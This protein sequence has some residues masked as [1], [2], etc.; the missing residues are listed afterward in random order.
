VVPQLPPEPKVAVGPARS[1]A[2]RNRSTRRALIVSVLVVLVGGL[3]AFAGARALTKHSQVI[4]V[5]KD[6]PI[7][8][9]ITEADL[10]VASVSKDPNV[11]PVPA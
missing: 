3:A 10:T 6:V 9:T 2:A 5:S 1:A 11:T 7:G 4:A 8:T